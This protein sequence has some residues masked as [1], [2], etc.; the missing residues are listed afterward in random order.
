MIAV[1]IVEKLIK[2]GYLAQGDYTQGVNDAIN[3]IDFLVTVAALLIWQWRA[4]HPAK[5]QLDIDMPITEED[6]AVQEKRIKKFTN[7]VKAL[8]AKYFLEKPQQ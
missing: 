4:H 3:I 7:Q 1:L 8:F 6:K 2:W 5:A